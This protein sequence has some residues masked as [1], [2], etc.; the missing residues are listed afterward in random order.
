MVYDT[1][2]TGT[3]VAIIVSAAV[4]IL[5]IDKIAQENLNCCKCF[6]FEKDLS[7]KKFDEVKYDFSSAFPILIIHSNAYL[8]MIE[9]IRQ[10]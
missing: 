1:L 5:P 9:L 7:T 2:T 3:L 4:F 8:D 6:K 10:Q